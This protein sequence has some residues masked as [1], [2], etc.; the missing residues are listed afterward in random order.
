MHDLTDMTTHV[1]R[2]PCMGF[3]MNVLHPH[4]LADFEPGRRLRW[5]AELAARQRLLEI[6]DRERALQRFGR[7]QRMAGGEF[8]QPDDAVLHQ[9]LFQA[10]MPL[11]IIGDAEI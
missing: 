3:W 11:L 1:A 6:I 5:T 10:Y 9:H 7:M 2:Q 4:A 8:I